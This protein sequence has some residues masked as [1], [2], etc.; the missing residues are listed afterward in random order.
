[1]LILKYCLL[2]SLICTYLL[3]TY[4][5]EEYHTGQHKISFWDESSH[6]LLIL[7]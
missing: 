7:G 6:P 1:M 4:K 2:A 5:H 3:R